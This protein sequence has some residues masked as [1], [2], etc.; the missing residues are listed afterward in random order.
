MNIIE[1]LKSSINT[2]LCLVLDIRN[3]SIVGSL[4]DFGKSKK[5]EIIATEKS[6]LDFQNKP[7]SEKLQIK[8]LECLGDL[9]SKIIRLKTNQKSI[10]SKKIEKTFITLSS[11]WFF[12]KSKNIEIKNEK[13]FY[14]T[15]NFINEI[16]TKESEEFKNTIVNQ[17]PDYKDG[18]VSIESSITNVSIRGYSIQDPVGKKTDS[19]NASIYLS[20]SKKDFINKIKDLI[21]KSISKKEEGVI[22][23]SFPVSFFGAINTVLPGENNYLHFNITGEITE[24]TFIRN[25]SIEGQ[26]SF[27][28]GKNTFVR[29]IGKSMDVPFQIAQSFLNLYFDRKLNEA[30]SS[31]IIESLN[32]IEDEWNIYLQDSLL[33]LSVTLELPKKIFLTTDK[34]FSDI[35]SSMLKMNKADQTSIWRKNLNILTINEKILKDFVLIKNSYNYSDY[36][37]LDSIFLSKFQ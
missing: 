5:P 11:P 16:L 6:V 27:P 19:L 2:D 34:N 4:V 28:V 10:S 9:L 23:H 33:A 8:T 7:D 32:Q 1:K 3:S 17:N 26:T 18:L 12:S 37:A 36:I 15:K 35:F 22:I 31:K 24:I 13:S 25:G 29:Q 21:Y 14:I 20:V 30:L